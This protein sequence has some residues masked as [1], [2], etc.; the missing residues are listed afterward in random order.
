MYPWAVT[1]AAAV[2]IASVFALAIS[3]LTVSALAY[4]PKAALRADVI[5][6]R[7]SLIFW[8]TDEPVAYEELLTALSARLTA[9]SFILLN[10]APRSDS[11]TYFLSAICSISRVASARSSFK[12]WISASLASTNLTKSDI[13]LVR[14]VLTSVSSCVSSWRTDSSALLDTLL[15]EPPVEPPVEPPALVWVRFGRSL[16]MS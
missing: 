13:C 8:S 15:E 11:V 9:S 10:R 14:V 12:F 2:S 5:S 4:D 16:F 6:E 1:L 7:R 3:A